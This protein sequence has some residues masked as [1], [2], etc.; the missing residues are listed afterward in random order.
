M[1]LFGW[2]LTCALVDKL[3]LDC[4]FLLVSQAMNRHLDN[5]RYSC[6]R[7]LNFDDSKENQDEEILIKRMHR[8]CMIESREKE[9]RSRYHFVTSGLNKYFSELENF[10]YFTKLNI[11]ASIKPEEFHNI[12]VEEVKCKAEE[13]HAAIFPAKDELSAFILKHINEIVDVLIRMIRSKA[14][15][16]QH[17]DNIIK[18]TVYV[19]KKM[20]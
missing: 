5:G 8:L 20:V 17:Q 3:S 13:E 16:Q 1:Y 12:K 2:Y 14:I 9:E 18:E 6:K 7:R 4:I 15:G 19:Y 11:M 10:R